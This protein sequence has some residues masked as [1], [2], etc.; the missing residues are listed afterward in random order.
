MLILKSLSLQL[1]LANAIFFRQATVQFTRPQ[2]LHSQ[3]HFFYEDTLYHLGWLEIP[4][5]WG[6][7][8]AHHPQAIALCKA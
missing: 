6:L 5:S 4:K 2:L 7:H 1:P 3:S 8:S